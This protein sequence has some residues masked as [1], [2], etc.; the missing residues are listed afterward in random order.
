M[1]VQVI[2]TDDEVITQVD[3]TDPSEI[4]VVTV[5][6]GQ[7]PPGPPGTPGGTIVTFNQASPSAT[8]TIDHDLTT[9]AP[10]VIILLTG[11]TQ[12]VLTDIN[13]FTGQIVLTFPSPVSGTAYVK[14]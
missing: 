12:P 9:L 6:Y 8:W 4:D 11:Q 2:V 14:P 13:Y 5:E 7:G 1:P 3:V 10:T